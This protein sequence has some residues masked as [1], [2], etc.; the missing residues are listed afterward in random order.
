MISI[1][2][3]TRLCF[4]HSENVAL[5]G[6]FY[7]VIFWTLK[8]ASRWVYISFIRT[9]MLWWWETTFCRHR[10]P[11]ASKAAKMR[12]QHLSPPIDTG[13]SVMCLNF[14]GQGRDTWLE[15]SMIPTASSLVTEQSALLPTAAL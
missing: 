8:D 13:E 14:L 15:Q 5:L 10:C 2:F 12:R 4:Y 6:Q 11:A 3:K 1:S 9:F 7:I